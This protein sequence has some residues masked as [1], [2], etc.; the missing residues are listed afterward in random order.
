MNREKANKLLGMTLITAF[1][2]SFL[3]VSLDG[4]N[5]AH[6]YFI[7]KFVNVVDSIFPAVQK[8]SM[9]TNYISTA[10]IS[11][12]IQWIFFPLYLILLFLQNPPWTGFKFKKGISAKMIRKSIFALFFVFILSLLFILSDFGM[13]K[14]SI[15]RGELFDPS[16]G[17]IWLRLPFEGRVGLALASFMMPIMSA[18]FYWFFVYFICGSSVF[19]SRLLRSAPQSRQ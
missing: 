19:L 11:I 10:R 5:L 18:F 16:F 14:I 1:L 8:I 4:G 6:L 17:Y 12:A 13:G 7:S 2:V 15:M 3:I 9:K